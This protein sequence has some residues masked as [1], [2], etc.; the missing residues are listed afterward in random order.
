[1]STVI[2]PVAPSFSI[3]TSRPREWIQTHQVSAYFLLTFTISWSMWLIAYLARDTV[4]GY[5]FF[6]LG[7]F[8]PLM[9]AAT[10]TRLTGGSIKQWSRSIIHWRVPARWYLFALGLPVAIWTLINIELAVLGQD[11]D[12]SLLPGRLVTAFGTFL[13]VLTVGGGF[14]EPGWRGFALGRLQQRFSPVKATLLLGFVWGLWHV[15]LYGPLAPVLITTLAFFYTYLYNKTHSLLLVI[16]LHATIT[17][18]ND[19]L[20]LTSRTVHGTTDVVIFGTVL[21]SAIVLALMT[22]GRLGFDP[23]TEDAFITTTMP[24]TGRKAER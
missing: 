9:A 19:T 4:V 23:K 15:P 6:G 24:P 11:I 20:I 21:A 17:P 7:G 1:M 22:R 16:L 8:G 14:E 5:V 13:L 3:T 2:D 10:I 12:V 18:A